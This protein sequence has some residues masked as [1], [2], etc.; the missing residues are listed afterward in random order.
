M[1]SDAILAIATISYNKEFQLTQTPCFHRLRES[2]ELWQSKR[3]FGRG[4]VCKRYQASGSRIALAIRSNTS[5]YPLDRPL[6]DGSGCGAEGTRRHAS[7]EYDVPQLL[8]RREV[9]RLQS[10]RAGGFF[11]SHKDGGRRGGYGRW[12]DRLHKRDR[13]DDAGRRDWSTIEGHHVQH[14]Q[15][16]HLYVRPA[17][18]QVNRRTKGRKD[19]GNDGIGCDSDLCGQGNGAGPWP[20]SRQGLDLYCHRRRGQFPSGAPDRNS[21]CGDAFHSV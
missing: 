15:S 2:P 17:H 21:R 16:A 10:R 9:R 3:R 11:G 8:C 12:R 18:D 5:R 6:R 20:E 1:T 4:D 13:V 7:Q 19:C 14:G